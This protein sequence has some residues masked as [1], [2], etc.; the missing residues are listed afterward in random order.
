MKIYKIK[1]LLKIF[2][3]NLIN[4]YNFGLQRFFKK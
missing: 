2:E 1:N 4:F 3:Y